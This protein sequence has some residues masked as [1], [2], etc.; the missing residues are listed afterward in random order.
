MLF[1]PFR[2]IQARRCRKGKQ[3]HVML[4][5]PLSRMHARFRGDIVDQGESKNENGGMRYPVGRQTT[6]QNS[7]LKNRVRLRN[8]K[9]NDTYPYRKSNFARQTQ[10]YSLSVNFTMKLINHQVRRWQ[11]NTLCAVSNWLALGW[12]HSIKIKLCILCYFII[13]PILNFSNRLQQIR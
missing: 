4:I 8:W 2:G 7:L 12:A 10:Y 11:Q 1:C 3:D 6:G 5:C 13:G 9:V